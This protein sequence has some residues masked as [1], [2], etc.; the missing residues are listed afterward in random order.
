MAVVHL[1]SHTHWDREWYLTFQQFR[2]KLVHLID[3]LLFI[4][5]TNPDYRYFM[6][7]GHTIVLEDYLEIRPEREQELRQ[8]IQ[9]GRIGYAIKCEFHGRIHIQPALLHHRQGALFT[10][11]GCTYQVKGS[12]LYLTI[13]AYS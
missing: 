2:V 7:D 6:L 10:D 4:L 5:K 3:K 9:E 12:S 1:V 13:C 11:R 8:H